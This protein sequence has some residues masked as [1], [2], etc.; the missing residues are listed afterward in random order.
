M[1]GRAKRA[2]RTARRASTTAETLKQERPIGR[3][4]EEEEDGHQWLRPNESSTQSAKG[5]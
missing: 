4:E 2:M 3:R 5:M 1:S